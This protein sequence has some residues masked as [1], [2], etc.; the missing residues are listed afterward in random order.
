[1][2][3]KSESKRR[4]AAEVVRTFTREDIIATLA[5]IAPLAER[6][7]K[8]RRRIA[9]TEDN[10]QRETGRKVATVRRVKRINPNHPILTTDV[11]EM[12]DDLREDRSI[13]SEY[14]SKLEYK[15]GKVRRATLAVVRAA[16]PEVWAMILTKAIEAF[17]SAAKDAADAKAI[18]VPM[19]ENVASE[20]MRRTA[21]ES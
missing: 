18:A 14:A 10:I 19:F 16:G 7:V 12:L 8:L 21:V 4:G 3:R 17:P 15:S 5:E 20:T 9:R 1:M 2:P 11:L 13:V 6:V